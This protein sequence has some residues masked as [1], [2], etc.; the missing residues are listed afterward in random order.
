MLAC[1][2]SLSIQ[3]CRNAP[4]LLNGEVAGAIKVRGLVRASPVELVK[5]VVP[6]GL[7]CLGQLLAPVVT[8]EVSFHS[9][10]PSL[11]ILLATNRLCEIDSHT[12]RNRHKAF[13]GRGVHLQSRVLVSACWA[14]IQNVY[15][16]HE[17]A[18]C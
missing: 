8:I 1:A 12:P 6:C 10:F 4:L 2:G 18:R 15:R 14:Y 11:L 16:F 3:F 9:C 13:P 17:A 5:K 7:A